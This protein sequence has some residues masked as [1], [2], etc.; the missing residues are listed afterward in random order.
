MY[1]HNKVPGWIWSEL[2]RIHSFIY[3]G[4]LTSW[5]WVISGGLYCTWKTVSKYLVYDKRSITAGI[6]SNAW[7][8][9]HKLWNS[10][11]SEC[12]NIAFMSFSGYVL[13][14]QMIWPLE[15]SVSSARKWSWWYLPFRVLWEIVRSSM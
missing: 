2:S 1:L 6:H 12:T 8:K 11:I 9:V 10:N 13:F 7:Q 4:E 5:P 3:L 14:W 15:A